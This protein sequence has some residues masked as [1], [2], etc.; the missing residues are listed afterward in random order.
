MADNLIIDYAELSFR[1]SRLGTTISSKSA[2]ISISDNTARRI[3]E[4]DGGT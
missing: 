3:L 1:K 4:M 2:N